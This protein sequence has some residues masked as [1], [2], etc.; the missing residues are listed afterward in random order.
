MATALHTE[1]DDSV[2]SREEHTAVLDTTELRWFAYGHAPTEVL[3]WFTATTDDLSFESRADVYL[4]DGRADR[5]VKHRAGR[6]LEVK[7]RLAIGEL[8]T[9]AGL[10][11]AVEQWRRWSP[12]RGG[13]RLR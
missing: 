9:L 2:E 3:R 8:V 10:Q 13:G 4:V 7:Q 6:I 12:A 5:G 11:G 1:R